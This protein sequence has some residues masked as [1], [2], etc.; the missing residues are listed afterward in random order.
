MKKMDLHKQFKSR[1]DLKYRDMQVKFDD[2]KKALLFALEIR[3]WQLP[4]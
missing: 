4:V 3:L 1:Q 2:L